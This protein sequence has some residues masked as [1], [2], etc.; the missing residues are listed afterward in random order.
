MT[1]INSN[2]NPKLLSNEHLL[3][4]HREIKR[5]PTIYSKNVESYRTRQLPKEFTLGTGHVLFFINKPD[6]T[7]NRY[8]LLYEECRSR[9]FEVDDYSDNWKIYDIYPIKIEHY[10]PSEKDINLIKYRIKDRISESKKDIYHH[11]K[12]ILTKKET[13][14]LLFTD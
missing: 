8:K 14:D 9:G 7:L 11:H 13:I 2:L 1:R 6:F 5:L 12:N 3:A 4:E 10:I